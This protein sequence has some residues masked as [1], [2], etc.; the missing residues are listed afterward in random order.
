MATVRVQFELDSDV[1]PELFEALSALR[2]TQARNERVRQLATAGLVWENVR[3]YGAA[4]IGP[5]LNAPDLPPSPGLVA[6]PL[7][8][9]GL[10]E[11]ERQARHQAPQDTEAF[12]PPPM[13]AELLEI[14]APG[15][16]FVDLAI[17]AKCEVL[18]TDVPMGSGDNDDAQ[19]SESDV[20]QVASELPVLLDIV[21]DEAE[22]EA[23]APETRTPPLYVVT[24]SEALPNDAELRQGE[25]SED[26]IH[27]A[28]LAQKPAMRSRLMRM[29]ER[30]LFKNG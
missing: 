21:P 24:P 16:D 2:S 17:N 27:L 9:A 29:K 19:I 3:I 13:L 26:A 18:E 4:A 1:Y 8:G 30:G 23:G 14:D 28:S 25:R 12:R 6:Q 22:V 20:E 5:N 10:G 15:A 7:V 11:R